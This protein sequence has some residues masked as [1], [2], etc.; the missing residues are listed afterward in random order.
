VKERPLEA[1]EWRRKNGAPLVIRPG[2][3]E[4]APKEIVKI[5]K[6]LGADLSHTSMSHIDRTLFKPGN[7]Y[8]FAQEGCFLAYDEWGLEG[9]YP[10]SLSITDILNDTQRIGQI[11][12]LFNHG[13]GSQILIAHDICTKCR[14]KGFGGHGYRHIL[15]NAMP[16]M[17]RRGISDEQ[18]RSLLIENP[19]NFFLFI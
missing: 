15:Y 13:C 10:E 4:D 11:K 19:K 16:A 7:R 1:L 5:L 18:I 2:R 6:E 8:A 17:R 9:Y 12:D 3:H 14:Y